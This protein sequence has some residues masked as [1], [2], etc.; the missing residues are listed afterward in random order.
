MSAITEASNR[1][2]LC[3][4]QVNPWDASQFQEGLRMLFLMKTIQE[5]VWAMPPQTSQ[6]LKQ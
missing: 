2:L 5:Y 4:Q 3:L 6:Y 1:I